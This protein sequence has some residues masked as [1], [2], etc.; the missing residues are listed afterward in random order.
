MS[1]APKRNPLR[2]EESSILIT[3]GTSGVGLATAIQFAEAGAPHIGLNGRNRERGEAACKAVLERVPG[4][5][6]EFF[7]GDVNAL[8]QA[9]AVGEAAEKAFGRIDVLVNSTV[10]AFPVPTLFHEIDLADLQ[11]MVLTQVMAPLNMCGV[12]LPGM[13]QREN[14]CIVNI[15]SDAGKLTTPGESVIGAM[16]AA[17]I[18]FSRALAMEAKRYGVRVN[19]LTP[20]LVEGTMMYSKVRSSGFS[21][22]LFE[23]AAHLA[24]LGLA[25]PQDLAHL[26][27]YLA[28]PQA[29]RMTGQAISLNGGISA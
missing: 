1:E 12:V 5:R 7:A 24:H 28:S 4:A 6:V 15:A 19:V 16:M 22:R 20:S 23:K 10:T 18:M 26:V 29:A 11:G 25:Q 13:R 9:R 8:D 3:G 21:A 2:L 17:I 27:V 14:G